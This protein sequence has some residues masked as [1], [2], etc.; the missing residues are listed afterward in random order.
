MGRLVSV[1]LGQFSFRALSLFSL[2]YSW[3]LKVFLEHSWRVSH[4]WILG[5]R[6]QRKSRKA[7]EGIE[8]SSYNS[9]FCKYRVAC[10]FSSLVLACMA[11]ACGF[12]VVICH[13]HGGLSG[14][15]VDFLALPFLG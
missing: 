5:A 3:R 7:Q 12:L 14:L 2:S 6:R 9:F 4:T 11:H 15:T 13:W 8:I 10:M 1:R